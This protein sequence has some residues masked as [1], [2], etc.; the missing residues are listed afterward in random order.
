MED[1]RSKEEKEADPYY[2]PT[3]SEHYQLNDNLKTC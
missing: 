3:E 1:K 2:K